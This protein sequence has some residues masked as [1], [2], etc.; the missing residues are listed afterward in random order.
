MEDCSDGHLVEQAK[1]GD[2]EAFAELARRC[3]EKVYYT[4][5]ALTKN[6]QDA[7]DLAQEAFMQ[8]FKSLKSFKQ[9]SSFYTWIYRIA[10]NLTLNF[11]KRRKRE[12]G[13]EVLNE[14]HS[15][16]KESEDPSFSPDE[17]SLKKELSEK[18]QEAIDSLPLSYRGS[19][20]LVV[21]QGMTHGQAARIL[22]CSENTVSWRMHKARKMLQARLKPYLGG[23]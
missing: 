11:L 15:V 2:V 3:Q 1:Q 7:S 21:F 17:R 4:L 19:F 10:V 8:A 23:G 22:G 6:Q 12:E 9:R 14:S 18:L 5:L 20:T 13:R 16:D